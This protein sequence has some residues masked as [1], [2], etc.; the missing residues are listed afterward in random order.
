MSRYGGARWVPAWAV[1]VVT[2]ATAIRG[3]VVETLWWC[4]VALGVL[5]AIAATGWAF[6]VDRPVASLH[7]AGISLGSGV[8]VTWVM[9]VGWTP[10]AITVAAVVTLSAVILEVAVAVH[11][12]YGVAALPGVE[13]RSSDVVRLELLLQRLT[14]RPVRVEGIDPWDDPRD[15]ERATVALPE[16]LSF[17]A[18]AERASDIA[19]ALHLPNG[20]VVRALSGSHQGEM[21]LD[22]MRRSV[23][24]A[25][26][27]DDSAI[28][29]TSLTANFV[30]GASP[31]GELLTTCLR[32]QSMAVGGTVGSGKTTFL[33][34]LI[35]FLARCTD[36]L[37]WVI[38]LNG[39]GVAGPWV[40]PYARGEAK[41][42][43][44]DWVAGSVEEAAVMVATARAITVDR[45]TAREVVR[46]RRA[47]NTNVL[48]V[49][50]QLPAIMIITDEGGEVQQAAG[51]L[52]TLVSDGVAR[53]AQIGRAEGCRVVMSVL[54]GTSDLLNKG[55]RT[56]VGVRVC[57]RMAE[58]D[59]YGHI[60]GA[61]IGKGGTVHVGIGQLYIR[62]LG[63]DR[64][65]ALCTGPDVAPM[66]IE[67]HAVATAHLRPELDARGQAIAAKVTVRDVLDGR[68]PLDYADIAR[69]PV[70]RDVEEGRA[71][72]GRWE[73]QK[74]MLAE[75]R[76]DDFEEED[77]PPERVPDQ[78]TVAAAGTAAE[79]LLLGTGTGSPAPSPQKK[80][81]PPAVGASVEDEARA[82]LSPEHWKLNGA[83][84]VRG[85]TVTPVPTTARSAISL[86]LREA[87]PDWLTASQIRER[88]AGHGLTVSAQRV[89][90]LLTAMVGKGEVCK[91]GN[92]YGIP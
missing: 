27:I 32:Q 38:D 74:A 67:A 14:G 79:R 72:S 29:P 92:A 58:D 10:S 21:I 56:V 76:G 51:L 35:K 59:E 30:I 39:G 86:V 26:R 33:H 44:V 65:P 5:A 50:A 57:F 63:E 20:C 6:A 54:R 60:L 49:D 48:P 75:L 36:T 9:V 3:E 80:E 1:A 90:E 40:G 22:I 69:L 37:V 43:T 16:G 87:H 7:R 73:R 18:L 64:Y 8:W 31:R 70:M 19:E 46:R 13:R 4:P 78:P 47:G 61:R 42:P 12:P 81:A 41:K 2:T 17:K 91:S 68:N 85:P 66:D 77:T 23:V 52:G 45:K 89:H 53:L 82:L 28:S 15:G 11:R 55:L 25:D 83:P 88:I 84:V 34:R 71:Y 24:H 62:R